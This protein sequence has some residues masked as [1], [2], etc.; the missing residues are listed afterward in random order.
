MKDDISAHLSNRT[1]DMAGLDA[2]GQ[3][4]R[5]EGLKDKIIFII[6]EMHFRTWRPIP[7]ARKFHGRADTGKTS[8][9]NDD[10]H[11]FGHRTTSQFIEHMMLQNAGELPFCPVA[12]GFHAPVHERLNLFVVKIT[13]SFVFL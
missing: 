1:E 5:Q 4:F 6:D 12:F 9:E 7:P 11:R 8:A 2:A 3:H 10:F 13:Q